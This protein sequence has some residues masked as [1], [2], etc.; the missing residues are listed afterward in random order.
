[1]GNVE[2]AGVGANGVVFLDGGAVAGRH[3]PAA[4]LDHMGVE[5]KG[6]RGGGEWCSLR[7]FGLDGVPFWSHPH[8]SPLPSRER[9]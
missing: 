2:H 9:G 5:G 3:V 1:M 7:V 6:G 4:E 8:L